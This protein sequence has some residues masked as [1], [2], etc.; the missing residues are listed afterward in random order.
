MKRIAKTLAVAITSLAVFFSGCSNNVDGTVGN[1][2]L[3]TYML[4]G[5]STSSSAAGVIPAGI[6]GFRDG[7]YSAGGAGIRK[8]MDAFGTGNLRGRIVE[9]GTKCGFRPESGSGGC[10]PGV[11]SGV[12][13]HA[14]GLAAAILYRDVQTDGGTGRSFDGSRDFTGVCK[15][16]AAVGGKYGCGNQ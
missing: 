11:L 9:G 5:S 10:R 1:A 4:G 15:F 12:C 2:L 7:L 14:A 6:A 13:C 8:G 3:M 16:P